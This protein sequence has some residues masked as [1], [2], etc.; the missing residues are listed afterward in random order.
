VT[1]PRRLR[2]RRELAILLV[3][4]GAAAIGIVAYATHLTRSL[5]LQSVDARFSIRGTQE[6]PDDIAVVGIDDGLGAGTI[7]ARIARGRG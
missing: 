2:R 7:A 3:V 1:T 4:V 5:E 6:Q